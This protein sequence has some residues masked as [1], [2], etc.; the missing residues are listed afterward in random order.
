VTRLQAERPAVQS[1]TEV[2]GFS[3]L[4]C[5][6][7]GSVAQT[8]FYSVGIRSS[9]SVVR[10]KRFVFDHLPTPEAEFE[11]EWSCSYAP[12]LCLRGLE[13]NDFTCTM[14]R[15]LFIRAI[16]GHTSMNVIF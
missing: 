14:S 15:V 3:L 2:R 12:T 1:L 16:S 5:L 4:Q 6:Q 10:R 7:P 8:A 11:N 9:S 13:M